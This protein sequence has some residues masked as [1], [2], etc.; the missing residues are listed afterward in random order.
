MLYKKFLEKFSITNDVGSSSFESSKEL[1]SEDLVET[2]R[3]LGGKTF[4]NGVYR[5][6]TGKKIPEMTKELCNVF[7]ECKNN[8]MCFGYDWLGRSFAVRLKSKRGEK[9]LQVL[10]LEPGAGEIMEIS[11]SIVDF[12]N[13]E[14]VNHANDALAIDFYKQWQSI[15]NK[16]IDPSQCVGYKVP[17]FLGGSDTIDN[18]ELIDMD[19][20]IEICG[21]LRNKIIDLPE[22]KTIKEI[23]IR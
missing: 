6:L 10:L 1:V 14:L 17:L 20:Y 3:E 4:N 16:P 18:L 22:G 12:H 11:A 5:V 21:Q 8:I 7:P 23:T 9:G 15:N 19:V 2:I 13:Y